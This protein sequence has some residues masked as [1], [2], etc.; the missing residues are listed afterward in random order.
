[1][2]R[3]WHVAGVAGRQRGLLALVA[4]AGLPRPQTN[5]R[6]AGFEVDA[7]WPDRHLVV[8]VD[9]YGTHGT[10]TAFER[11]RVRDARLQ[12][13]D[14]RVLRITWRQL[15]EAPEAV[16]ATLAPWLSPHPAG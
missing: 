7:L 13:A 14:L 2:E 5:V 12:A 3:E 16:V 4:R 10:R 1:M 9:A 11:Y 6:L 8:E 15:T